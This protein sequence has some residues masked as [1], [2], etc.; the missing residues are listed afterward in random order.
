M[1]L[2]A[3]RILGGGIRVG[4]FL[5]SLG[6]AFHICNVDAVESIVRKLPNEVCDGTH[7]YSIDRWRM[8]FADEGDLLSACIDAGFSVKLVR[9]PSS[10]T[11]VTPST[12]KEI[13]IGLELK[14]ESFSLA[15]VVGVAGNRI[16]IDRLCKR[17]RRL[18]EN[19][20]GQGWCPVKGIFGISNGDA[21]RVHSNRNIGS[22]LSVP[23]LINPLAIVQDQQKGCVTMEV[24]TMFFT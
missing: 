17:N 12:T 8:G 16:M 18:F 7:E 9:E 15:M 20:Y 3:N 4:F 19:M 10:E 6:Y 2:I 13:R 5:F 14:D 21:L 24:W 22:P 11:I 23:M 1:I